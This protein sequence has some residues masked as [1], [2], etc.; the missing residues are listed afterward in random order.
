M[1]IVPLLPIQV[2]TEGGR[3]RVDGE[4]I[5]MSWLRSAP[6][7][8]LDKQR[9][10]LPEVFGPVRPQVT[11]AH[12]RGAAGYSARA[13]S[14]LLPMLVV[15]VVRPSLPVRLSAVDSAPASSN[16]LRHFPMNVFDTPT[17]SAS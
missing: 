16:S 7:A 3:L 14:T 15:S 10:L 1:A 8:P 2:G 9:D 11:L 5:G 4:A 17:Y 6:A 13:A 12:A